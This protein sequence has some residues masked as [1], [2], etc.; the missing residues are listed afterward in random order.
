MRG[1]S[2]DS[3]RGRRLALL[4]AAAG[5]ALVV[6]GAG[7]C[8]GL[9]VGSSAAT[10]PAASTNGGQAAASA[11]RTS[12][13]AAGGADASVHSPT[14]SVRALVGMLQVQAG[15]LLLQPDAYRAAWQRMCTPAYWT[16]TG[17]QGAEE[18]LDTLA[19]DGQLV[20]SASRGE[21]VYVHLFP[22]TGGTTS[23]TDDRSSVQVWS[24]IVVHAG[25][26]PTKAVFDG[27]A[28][29]LAWDGGAW[30]LD[31]GHTF[32]TA[33]G[34]STGAFA[35]TDG[36]QLPVFLTLPGVDGDAASS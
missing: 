3:D 29:D 21:Q 12:H 30:K 28:A 6:G 2:E 27:V 13:P 23:Y 32:A 5:A 9:A 33:D 20:T 19:V 11:P 7:F 10:P 34:G 18:M 15:P 25:D 14:G 22:L 8:A 1:F 26:G 24:L 16:A 35:L 17:R 4:V 31:G 36:P